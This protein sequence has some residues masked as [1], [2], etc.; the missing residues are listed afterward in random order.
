M[1][2]LFLSSLPSKRNKVENTTINRRCWSVLTQALINK[3]IVLCKCFPIMKY[4][5]HEVG[6]QMCQKA[7]C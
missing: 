4:F 6:M 1:G 7:P 2:G 5:E 3:Q